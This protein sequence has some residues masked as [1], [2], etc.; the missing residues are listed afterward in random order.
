MLVTFSVAQ[1]SLFLASARF[2][3]TDIKS[4]L[5]DSR[6]FPRISSDPDLIDLQYAPS[7]PAAAPLMMRAPVSLRVI[8]TMGDTR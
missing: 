6:A 5:P 2:H 1:R 8:P 7:Q 3:E 4:Q